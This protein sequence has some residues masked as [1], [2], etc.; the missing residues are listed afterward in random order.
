M[1]VQVEQNNQNPIP[2]EDFGASMAQPAVAPPPPAPVAG[3]P[4]VQPQSSLQTAQNEAVVA[5][6][7]GGRGLVKKLLVIILV[8]LVLVGVGAAVYFLKDRVGL[9]GGEVEESVT[10][11]WWG[12]WEDEGIV[13][14]LIA[15][16][17]AANPGV[18]IVYEK[19]AKQDYRERLTSLFARGEG[20]DIFRFHNTWVPMLKNHLA[21]LPASVMGAAEF[22]QTYYPVV[23]ADMTS[24]TSLVGVPLMFDSLAL[25]INQDIFESFAKSPPRTWDEFRQ[26]A[27]ELTVRDKDGR[28]Q[29]AGA[30]L[31]TTSNVDHWPEI[32]G[33]MMLQNGVKMSEPTGE[34]AER[35]LT[36]YTVF[37]KEDN[38]WDNTLPNSTLAFANGKVAMYFGPSWRA[39]EIEQ[40]NPSLDYRVVVVPQL[41]KEEPNQTDVAFATYW[42][43]GVWNKSKVTS[44]AW[45]FLKFVSSRESLTKLYENAS[46]QRRFGEP[47]PRVDMAGLL[48]G[49]DVVGAFVEQGNYAKSWYLASRT[50]DGPT[51]INT[52][53]IKYFEDG[54]NGVLGRTSE[55]EALGTVANGVNQ[56]LSAYGLVSPIVQ[57]EK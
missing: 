42:V 12:L 11:T 43:E 34:L 25:Y 32:L 44:A 56:V 5:P 4:Q 55:R 29:Q 45:D 19:Q 53:I 51:G 16:Y 48:A 30:A 26:V 57:E 41:A 13:E 35:A 37:T 14:P 38:V 47:Y 49:D 6:K 27:N 18:D 24:G 21:S 52:Q 17:E 10:V 22:S 2:P 20:P 3:Q 39:F 50:N 40:I 8:L 1:A 46:K 7:Q 54:V 9:P 15:E 28:I 36:Y 23:A 31:G 33:L